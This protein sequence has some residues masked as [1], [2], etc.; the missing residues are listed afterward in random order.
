MNAFVSNFWD[1]Y[2]RRDMSNISSLV[3]KSKALLSSSLS[4][5]LDF[6]D[7]FGRRFQASPSFRISCPHRNRLGECQKQSEAVLA[8]HQRALGG[9]FRPVA[10]RAHR[11]TFCDFDCILFYGSSLEINIT[12]LHST[13]AQIDLALEKHQ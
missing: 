10:Q 9:I 4:G 6:I 1:S 12:A 5:Y 2:L 7:A 11:V 3:L 13:L 8:A